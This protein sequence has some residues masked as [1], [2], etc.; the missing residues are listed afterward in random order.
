MT[1]ILGKPPP[2]PVWKPGSGFPSLSVEAL[3]RVQFMQGVTLANHDS[4]Q[5]YYVALRP[6]S[7]VNPLMANKDFRTAIIKSLDKESY[8]NFV[9]EGHATVAKSVIGPRVFGYTEAAEAADIGF[10]LEGAK[11]L[12][13]TT[14]GRMRKSTSCAHLCRVYTHGRVLPGQHE[15]GGVQQCQD[16]NDR[17]VCLVDRKQNGRPL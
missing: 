15:G 11:K 7:F 14:A 3:P 17:L 1:V 8:V 4:A 16:G 5:I 10:D 2:W 12:I 9:L 6:N 13:Q